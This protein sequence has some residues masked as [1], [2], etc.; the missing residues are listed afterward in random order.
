MLSA[1]VGLCLLLAAEPVVDKMREREKILAEHWAT[2]AN[3]SR[4]QAWAAYRLVRRRQ[5]GFMA[6]ASQ[7]R[8]DAQAVDLA[9]AVVGRS[10]LE[11]RLN[12]EELAHVRAER[13]AV[14]ETLR[15]R[16]PA[17]TSAATATLHFTRPVAGTIVGARQLRRDPATGAEFRHDGVNIL[18]RMN[19]PVRAIEAGTVR[20]VAPLPQGGFAIVVEHA[21]GWVSILSGLRQTAVSEGTVVPGGQILGVA[22]R[23]LDGAAVV[24]FEL[25]RDRTSVDPRQAL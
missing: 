16:G 2:A 19:E 20:R 21:A 3:L 14:E 17:P 1:V 24:G 18:T 13:E 5:L 11:A 7:R 12:K 6:N 23:T 8:D 10:L 4:H 22:G 15:R 9:L 25:W